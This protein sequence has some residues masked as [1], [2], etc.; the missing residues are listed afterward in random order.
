MKIGMRKPSLKKSLKARTTAKWKRQAKRAVIPGYDKTSSTTSTA[1]NTIR[2]RLLPR[3]TR[4]M[5]P[6]ERT[7]RI[8]SRNC[9][10]WA[11]LVIKR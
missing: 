9:S 8:Q 2:R 5:A 1:G 6:F 7:V 3:L 4:Q 11:T 10:S